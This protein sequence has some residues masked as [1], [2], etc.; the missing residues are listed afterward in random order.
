MFGIVCYCLSVWVSIAKYQSFKSINLLSHIP[1][2]WKVKEHIST[3]VCLRVRTFFLPCGGHLLAVL[4]NSKREQANSP[5][6]LCIRTIILL[7]QNSTL[8]TSFNLNFPYKD[9]I[10]KYSHIR[11]WGFNIWILQEQ[12]HLSCYSYTIL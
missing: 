1:R 7:D 11:D 9:L 3:G 12:N 4:L 6:S 10:S 5:V 2:D 8:M